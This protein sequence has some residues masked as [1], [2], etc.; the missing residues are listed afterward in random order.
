M[1]N[2][3]NLVSKLNVSAKS[4]IQFTDSSTFASNPVEG[5][6]HFKDQILYI[7]ATINNISTWFPLTTVREKHIHSQGGPAVTWTVQH[8]LGTEN[9][10]FM[11]FDSDD[12]V[13]LIDRTNVTANSFTLEFNV[14]ETGRV[15]VFASKEADTPFLIGSMFERVEAGDDITIY[16]NMIPSADSTWSIG[17]SPLKWKEMHLSNGTLYAGDTTISGTSV[18]TTITGSPNSALQQPV[19]DSSA[20]SFENFNYNDGAAQSISPIIASDATLTIGGSN[21][22]M[23]LNGGTSNVNITAANFGI[24][25]GGVMNYSG[26]INLSNLDGGSW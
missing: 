13:M 12:A 3:I 5:Q 8:D 19:I 14:A 25:S 20:L 7:W 17:S 16:G 1:G 18:T 10:I 26:T 9:V 11:A 15:V 23:T 22:T 24:T 4:T 2:I 6:I 21:N